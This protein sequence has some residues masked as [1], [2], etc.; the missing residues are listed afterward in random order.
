VELFDYT[1]NDQEIVLLM[2]YCNDANYFEDKIE[3]R[4]TPIKNNEKLQ[5]YS[6]DIL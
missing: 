3:G 6:I 1:E 5:S 4:L 2:E